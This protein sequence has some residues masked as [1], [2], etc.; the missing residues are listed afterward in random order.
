MFLAS[1]VIGVI[2]IIIAIISVQFKNKTKLLFLQSLMN[3]LKV[4]SLLLVG[5]VSGAVSQGVGALRKIW[6]FKN[7]RK[8]K[9]NSILSLLFFCSLAIITGIITWEGMLSLLPISGIIF[10]TYGLWQENIFVLRY[11]CLLASINFA[12]YSFIVSA[13]TNGLS[14]LFIIVSTLIS[15]LRFYISNKKKV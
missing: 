15:L 4:F 11:F 5:G 12:I 1:Q 2:I 13:Y 9:L 6:F 8:N 14:E 3:I 10:A 7:S